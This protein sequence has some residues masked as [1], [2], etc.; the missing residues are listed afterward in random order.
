MLGRERA[1]GALLEAVDQG[2]DPQDVAL[3]AIGLAAR[4]GVVGFQGPEDPELLDAAA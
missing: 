2:R 4:R 3:E 1:H